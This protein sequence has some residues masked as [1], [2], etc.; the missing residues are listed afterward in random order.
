[1]T[2]PKWGPLQLPLDDGGVPFRKLEEPFILLPATPRSQ[3]FGLLATFGPMTESGLHRSGA[4]EGTLNALEAEGCIE[5][6]THKGVRWV[7][8]TELGD[9]VRRSE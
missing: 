5:R 8:L 9:V 4:D 7:Q 6:V 1:M 2:D 3:A